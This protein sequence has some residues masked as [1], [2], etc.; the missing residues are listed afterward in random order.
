MKKKQI[1]LKTIVAITL[2]S[3]MLVSA[4]L[5]TSN[6]EYFKSLNKTLSLEMK[7][8][9]NLS[10]YLKH[11]P[12]RDDK[13][14]VVRGTYKTSS[15]FTQ[16]IGTPT[17]SH[18]NNNPKNPY[19]SQE[20]IYQVRIPVDETGYYTLDFTT[21][22]LYGTPSEY[23]Q[24]KSMEVY[25][26]NATLAFGCEVLTA[27]DISSSSDKDVFGTDSWGMPYRIFNSDESTRD[28]FI[29]G[30][31]PLLYAD[32]AVNGGTG[33]SVYQW[34]SL[35]PSRTETVKLTFK[36]TD[37]DVKNG[38]VIWAWDLTGL[39]GG[40]NHTLHVENL[41][42]NKTMNLDGTTATRDSDDPYFMFPQTAISNN[43]HLSNGAG[44][45]QD[46]YS[47]GRGTYV[48]EATENSLG[49]R[50]EILFDE[51]VSGED[52][53]DDKRQNPLSLY[54]PLKNIE[55]DKT[56]KVTFDFSVAK[57]GNA[58][59][60]TSPV[61]KFGSTPSSPNRWASY[62]TTNNILRND[63]YTS[64]LAGGGRACWSYI[65][66]HN[67]VT[68]NMYRHSY[69]GHEGFMKRL[70]YANKA[71]QEKPLTQ[72][73]EVTKII[74]NQYA[75]TAGWSTSTSVNDTYSKNII[76][77]HAAE[78]MHKSESRNWFNAVEHTEYNGQNQINWLTFYN[79]TFSFNISSAKKNANGEVVDSE[80]RPIDLDNL[81]WIWMIDF[82][83][84]TAFY[85]IRIDN[86]RIQEVVE[87]SSSLDRNGVLFAENQ[88]FTTYYADKFDQETDNVIADQREDSSKWK[89]GVFVSFRGINGTGQNYQSKGAV[90]DETK[91]NLNDKV[92]T[93]EGNI[94]APIIDAK[95][96]IAAE[97]G[98][99]AYQIALSGYA[100][101]QGG[102]DR[103]VFSVDGG[104]TWHDMTLKGIDTDARKATSSNLTT[105]ERGINQYV[106]GQTRYNADTITDADLFKSLTHIDFTEADAANG[107]FQGTVNSTDVDPDP[108]M[109]WSLV[110]DLSEFKHQA[111]LDI[112][113]AAVPESNH[114]L[115]CEILRIINY[116]QIRNYRTY[117]DHIV[118]DI[119]VISNGVTSELSATFEINKWDGKNIVE[120][121]DNKKYDPEN[122]ENF[123]VGRG[124]TVDGAISS[125]GGYS[126][127]FSNSYD[128]ED[129]R[130]LFSDFPVKKTLR[131]LGYALVEG[132]V[133]SYWWSAD[134]GK[135]WNPCSEKPVDAT[136]DAQNTIKKQRPYWFDGGTE[137]DASISSH[138][139]PQYD[140]KNHKFT[141]G[142]TA[143]LS[144][145]EGEIVDVIF[146]AKPIG[147]DVY[148]PVAKVDNVAVYGEQG[149]FY[150]R[151]HRVIIDGR[152]NEDLSGDENIA[153]L[154]QT[155][156]NTSGTYLNYLDK[157]N[158]S[159]N[160]ESYV[161]FEPQNVNA[162]NARYITN[163]VQEI[164][165][166]GRVAI[167]GYVM[168]KG[169]VSRYKFS[170][171]GGETWTVINDTGTD[172]SALAA[173]HTMIA[174]SKLSD[175][176]FKANPD[177]NNGDFC[178]TGLGSNLDLNNSTTRKAFYDHALEFNIP[179]LPQ[180]AERDLLVVAENDP[181]GDPNTDDGK[182][183]PV[184]HI[185]IKVK[186]TKFGYQN[187]TRN[188]DLTKLNV[189]AGYYGNTNT[190]TFNPE[191]TNRT[192]GVHN[193]LNRITIPVTETGEHTLSFEHSIYNG[194][195][196]YYKKD[197][198]LYNATGVK[199]SKD[200]KDTTAEIT[201]TANKT[202]YLVGEQID[203]DLNI[204]KSTGAGFGYFQAVIVSEDWL[205]EYDNQHAIYWSSSEQGLDWTGNSGTWSADDITNVA[206]SDTPSFSGPNTGLQSDE[207]NMGAGKYKIMIIHRAKDL[208][209]NVST[210]DKPIAL[211]TRDF[212]HIN[213]LRERF[214]I[215]EVPIY[216]HDP[217]EKV[218]F[219]LVHDEGE[220]T[221]F[222]DVSRQLVDGD[223]NVAGVATL[224]AAQVFGTKD[225]TGTQTNS[226]SLNIDVTEGDVRRG[227]VILDT[228]YTGL[229]AGNEHTVQKC[230]NSSYGTNWGAP[231][232]SHLHTDDTCLC[233]K[234]GSDSTFHKQV[235]GDT[236]YILNKKFTDHSIAISNYSY[237]TAMDKDVDNEI[238]HTG[239]DYQATFN[240]DA[241]AL[242]KNP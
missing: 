79:T 171:D 149:T 104:K 9:L 13:L 90:L 237:N 69:A 70:T 194:P 94:Y 60:G 28:N 166:G 102:I 80:N 231:E 131:V 163:V 154:T 38:Y 179:A 121:T 127:R 68:E 108:D 29:N 89:K 101:C 71:Y 219:S 184:L 158:I 7:P 170:L 43:M 10:Y 74:S 16:L 109:G 142:I 35:C 218:D 92:F 229:W 160:K 84:Y 107:N 196:T 91:P 161:I 114:D 165:S 87:Y 195:S 173:T 177:G 232:N 65:F 36:V 59:V 53:Q 99:H 88:K 112:I 26:V 61:F 56:Y 111:N 81:Y 133:D 199:N 72:Y 159:Y 206:G 123:T 20:V 135:N 198:Q 228:N 86:V 216:I 224:T 54:I 3:A 62:D 152:T 100:V 118:S 33:D 126:L 119:S 14:E 189:Q 67:N 215:A 145:Y 175:S 75:H 156:A 49:L 185:K 51:N 138:F 143:D 8:D 37:D 157:W 64:D 193:T 41:S 192:G 225:T 227:Y 117:T 230:E 63:D 83:K 46:R 174:N 208:L 226:L 197:R 180:G 136:G 183:F 125:G 191:I 182:E 144:A 140:E 150:T 214:L 202:H 120:N 151:V 103:Y 167:D 76:T 200:G 212:L 148:V 155:Y 2:L 82:L 44:A 39:E 146:C 129:I 178:C 57:Q 47:N 66:S 234:A 153:V 187:I 45:G 55:Y 97:E 116:N 30:L 128:Y 77:E 141:G 186:N 6:A 213:G 233:R 52:K 203:I 242:V 1:F 96:I 176:S 22:T 207:M 113:I 27:T 50:A 115:R 58:S 31:K 15:G 73:D 220:Y 164:E 205:N 147:S 190:L 209:V 168:C 223:D 238:I 122:K 211:P 201:L 130:T 210:S 93:C 172:M 24:Y 19:M 17:I 169:G 32:T 42:I 110:A 134:G 188:A 204:T 23:E 181:D 98:E 78:G 217:D 40:Y 222:S 12:K 235:N 241:N 11:S 34:K 137:F 124:V 106:S 48:T 236:L 162:A 239:I 5:G 105:A 21:Y 240:F 139:E 85:N 132:D 95:K 18:F 4:F 25:T 221:Y